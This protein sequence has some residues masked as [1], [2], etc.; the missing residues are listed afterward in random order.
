MSS[1]PLLP[2]VSL[3]P[4][5]L[6]TSLQQEHPDLTRDIIKGDQTLAQVL[7]AS[8]R[9]TLDYME[10][11]LPQPSHAIVKEGMRY[12]RR[13]PLSNDVEN[14]LSSLNNNHL[15][16]DRR[17]KLP[18]SSTYYKTSASKGKILSLM[19][20][21]LADGEIQFEEQETSDEI[22]RK[23]M[24]LI[25]SI[26]DK[27]DDL[28]GMKGLLDIEMKENENLG[29]QVNNLTKSVCSAKEHEK[30]NFFVQ[31]VDKI[32]N[33]LLSLSGRLARVE[34]AIQMLP[35]DAE[36]QEM[37]LLVQKR[38]KLMEQ[39]TE[40]KLLKENIDR[41]QKAVSEILSHHFDHDQFADYEHYIKMKSA[42][43][44][45]QRELDDKSK[46]GR[47]QM[48]CL[49]DSLPDEWQNNLDKLLGE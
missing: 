5:S 21:K 22:N 17:E 31:D 30:Y 3:F 8:S 39:H 13:K 34:N 33:L 48:Q 1:L 28:D 4:D 40:A 12:R 27:L 15:I 24:E 43:I 20:E 47:E 35:P 26:Q 44:M 23:K 37:N 6:S 14:H 49:R 42:L 45:E 32:I 9:K 19:K 16:H 25:L 2:D 7:T 10:G 41:R 29:K 11:V 46:L 38:T 36:K 18:A